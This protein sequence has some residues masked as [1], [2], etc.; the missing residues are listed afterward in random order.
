[1]KEDKLKEDN[2]T[3]VAQWMAGRFTF[4]WR[5]NVGNV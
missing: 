1:M 3:I 2:K 5:V 4:D